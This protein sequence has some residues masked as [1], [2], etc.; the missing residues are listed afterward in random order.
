MRTFV[1][2][3]FLMIQFQIDVYTQETV[4]IGLYQSAPPS[5]LE[6]IKYRLN[7]IKYFVDTDLNLLKD[8]TFV[9]KTCSVEYF[10]RWKVSADTLL[11]YCDSAAW[12]SDSLQINGFNG[13]W[14][15]MDT[16]NPLKFHTQ[17]NKLTMIYMYPND[18]GKS[19]C[20]MKL[21][22]QK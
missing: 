2:I 19:I 22:E 10:G 3:I 16:N 8:S 18:N 6:R 5:I 4:K 12:R 7:G 14:P 15:S 13:R 17:T 1:F 9:Y 21:K 11:L 20:R